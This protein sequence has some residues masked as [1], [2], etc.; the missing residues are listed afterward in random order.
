MSDSAHRCRAAL[1]LT[2]GRREGN[3]NTRSLEGDGTS[4]VVSVG[5][6]GAA[7]LRV[8]T[9]QLLSFEFG[10]TERLVG[11]GCSAA[12][13][14]KLSMCRSKRFTSKGTPQAKINEN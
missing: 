12:A 14:N 2:D 10:I 6:G 7:I 8:S 1:K 11:I 3:K 9:A 4:C 13:G 5:P